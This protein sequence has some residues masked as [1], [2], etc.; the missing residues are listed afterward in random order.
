MN[1]LSNFEIILRLF[2]AV[3]IGGIIGYEREF[4]N[5]PAGFR[6]NIL[7]CIGATVV[8]L[9]QVVSL[10][11]V[12]TMVVTHP[13]LQQVLKVDV[14]RMAAQVISGIGFLGAGAIIHEKGS[15]KGLTTAASLWT[16]ACIGIAIGMGYYFLSITSTILVVLILFFLKKVET[17]FLLKPGEI[18][19]QIET[20]KD[21]EFNAAKFVIDYF[22][23]NKI[24]VRNIE[25]INNDDSDTEV[26]ILKI[27]YTI[28][29]PRNLKY[30]QV[31]EII[32]S[33]EGV[34]NIFVL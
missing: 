6:T 20:E 14:G 3:V 29:L 2:I 12:S 24:K 22:N 23:I 28:I 25:Y 8:S 15:V 9:I 1:N 27:I 10:N 18:K 33:Y 4:N 11:E 13:G 5:M 7:V 21:T 32:R 30:L 34:G 16:V 17:K 19:V 26:D 31:E